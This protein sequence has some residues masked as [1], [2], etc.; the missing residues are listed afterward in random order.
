[1]NPKFEI[2]Q[3]LSGQFRFR[4]KARN[5]EIILVSE[6]YTQKH[7]CHSGIKSVRIHAPFEDS[8][9][10]RGLVDGRPYFNLR[11]SNGEIIGTSQMYSSNQAREVGIAAVKE[12]AVEA[13]VVE[14]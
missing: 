1:M 12:C 6:A 13:V 14:L 7:N 11:A 2:Y 9:F 10:L 3:D 4:L 8:Y 5:G